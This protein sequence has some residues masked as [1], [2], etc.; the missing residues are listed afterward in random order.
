M[1]IL[2]FTDK[3][4]DEAACKEHFKN[5]RLKQGIVCKCCQKVTKH[6]WL[7][8][9]EKFQ[10]ANKIDGKYC[11]SRTN[12][13]AG[14]LFEHT[15]LN[16]RTAYMIVHLMTSI[17]KSFSALEMQRQV[18]KN[19]Y[20]S[21]WY[22]M[23]KVRRAMGKRDSLYSLGGE[24]RTIELDEGHFT[25]VTLNDKEQ[26]DIIND[27][28]L[29]RGRGSQKQAKVLVMVESEATNQNKKYDKNRVMGFVKMIT[30]DDASS[31]TINYEVRKSVVKRTTIIS[32]NW[33]GYASLE[34][35]ADVI[36]KPE[37]TKPKQASKKLP[38]VH[39]QISNAK[40]IFLGTHHSVGIGFIQNYCNEF[41][42]KLNRR[43]F[44]RDRFDGLIKAAA[45]TTWY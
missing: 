39:C 44:K 14:T 43:N 7:K 38:W 22:F 11:N 34:S 3:F 20:E 26:T 6:Y 9:V 24:G 10:C 33:R 17:K 29:K 27:V 28:E 4:K 36:H 19:N 42:Y 30:I 15:K 16:F 40:K 1:N 25:V 37:T 13:K 2:E 8:G 5:E 12:L 45:S 32:D 23:H 35:K 21:I 41:T 31:K 18:G